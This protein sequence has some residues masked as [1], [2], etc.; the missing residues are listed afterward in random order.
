MILLIGNYCYYFILNIEC[1]LINVL[2][3]ICFYF[4]FIEKRLRKEIDKIL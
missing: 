3:N 4:L 1:I 2:F